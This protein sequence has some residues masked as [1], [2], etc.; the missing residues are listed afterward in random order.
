VNSGSKNGECYRGVHSGIDKERKKGQADRQ[1]LK[2]TRFG[3]LRDFVDLVICKTDLIF[4]YL[5][6]NNMKD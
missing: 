4:Q 1:K 6:K 3:R 5:Q 2:E